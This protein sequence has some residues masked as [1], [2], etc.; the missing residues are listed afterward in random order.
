MKLISIIITAEY[1]ENYI[2]KCIES[3]LKQ[4]T[5]NFELIVCYTKLKNENLLKK[6]FSRPNVKFLKIKKKLKNKTQDQFNKIFRGFKIS[7]GEIISLLDGDD[8]FLKNKL[9]KISFQKNIKFKLV[10]DNFFMDNKKLPITSNKL[11]FKNWL[12]YKIFIND[13]PKNIATSTISGGRNFFIKFF[14]EVHIKKFKFLAIDALAVLYAH[15]KNRLIKIDEYLTQ[16]IN[17][18][19][20]IDKNFHGILNLYYWK[21]RL[22]QHI[23]YRSLGLK[24]NYF[25]I[26]FLV[27]RIINIFF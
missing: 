18:E 11:Y 23:F 24:K 22:E 16:K 13:W 27:C 26:D 7:N 1:K 2:K 17:T 10:L 8:L 19:N 9:S 6:K 20:S 25:S 14:K 21:R 4:N 15:K 12:L 3:C 5:K